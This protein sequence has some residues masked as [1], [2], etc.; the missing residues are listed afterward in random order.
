VSVAGVPAHQLPGCVVVRAGRTGPGSAI[1]PP[2]RGGHG[3]RRVQR[4]S[5]PETPLEKRGD[6]DAVCRCIV[7]KGWCRRRGRRRRVRVT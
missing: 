3:T 5:V 7:F 2:R 4:D 6:D 1:S